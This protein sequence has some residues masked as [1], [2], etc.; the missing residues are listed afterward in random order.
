MEETE[1]EVEKKLKIM[2]KKMDSHGKPKEED[3]E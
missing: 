3:G 2:K 1:T